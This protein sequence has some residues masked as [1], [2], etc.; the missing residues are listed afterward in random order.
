MKVAILGASL[1]PDRHS[2]RAQK[3]LMEKGHEVIPV[4]PRGDDI[5]G[6]TGAKEVPPGVD[7]V[8]LYLSPKRFLPILD[9]LISASPRRVIFNPGTES[10][11][12][13]QRLTEAG[14]ETEDACTLVLLT[15]GNF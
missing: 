6:I 11:E 15:T 10:T 8:T 5:L 14:I 9:Q 4:S 7:T 12:A 3:L 2:H 13:V 1:K